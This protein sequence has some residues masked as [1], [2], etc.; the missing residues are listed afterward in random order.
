MKLFSYLDELQS[1]DNL[2]TRQPTMSCSAAVCQPTARHQNA[3]VARL[4][5]VLITQSVGWHTAACLLK[6]N[7]LGASSLLLLGIVALA[8]GIT[9]A[10]EARLDKGVT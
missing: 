3:A 7:R 4:Q 8:K 5:Q 6:I 10:C 1:T 2:L 9:P